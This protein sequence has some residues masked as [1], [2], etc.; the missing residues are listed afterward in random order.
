MQIDFSKSE[1]KAADKTYLIA[2]VGA[3]AQELI[4][5]GGLEE[6]VKKNI[7]IL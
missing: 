1:L 2:P 3:T 7:P 4:V 5:Y 6:W